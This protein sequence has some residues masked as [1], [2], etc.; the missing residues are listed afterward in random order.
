MISILKCPFHNNM[1]KQRIFS[2]CM[3]LRFFSRS[4]SFNFCYSRYSLNKSPRLSLL[5]ADF[6]PL[7]FSSFGGRHSLSDDKSCIEEARDPP[8]ELKLHSSTWNPLIGHVALLKQTATD[9]THGVMPKICLALQN[10]S[11]YR[12]QRHCC[13][14]PFSCSSVLSF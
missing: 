11:F 6:F 10:T 14:Q 4:S 7:R 5:C 12:F 9:F 1:L 3:S 2:K 8:E 13:D